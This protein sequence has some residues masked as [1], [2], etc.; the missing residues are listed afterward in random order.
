[1]QCDQTPL[2]RKRLKQSPQALRL[3]K[4]CPMPSAFSAIVQSGIANQ[5][6]T[7]NIK[8]RMLRECSMFMYG[9]CPNPTSV[10]YVEMAKALC[11]KYPQLQD[12]NPKNG[13]YWVSK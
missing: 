2:W 11:D 6:I 5:D 3:P 7:G 9:H 10:E 4:P 8:L 13:E 1:M 12:I